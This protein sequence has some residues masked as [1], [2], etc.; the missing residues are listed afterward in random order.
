MSF[1]HAV[2]A[3]E[4]REREL[5]FAVA[6]SKLV[7][8][9]G[10]DAG[11]PTGFPGAPVLP[12][13]EPHYLG[14]LDGVHCF[15]YAVD[16]EPALPEGHAVSDLRSLWS[17]VSEQLWAVAGKAVQIVDW[18]RTHRFCGRCGTPTERVDADRSRRCPACS[19]SAY[20]RL[21]PAVICVVERGDELLLA[22]G[23]RFPAPFYSALAGFV[24]PGESLEGA[25]VREIR[26]EVGVEVEN[27]RYYGSQ[28]WP[29][30]HS[31]M[32]G[33]HATWKSGEIVIDP[34]EIAD[35]R[36]FPKDD[37]PLIPPPLSIARTLIDVAVARRG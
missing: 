4:R 7:T 11:G 36:F 12:A 32:I 30:P 9:T 10:G 5:W 20:P 14:G 1:D 27:V 3:P 28:P 35:A 19:L 6:G 34:S 22:H 26:E 29:F 18:D 37:L 31:L 33:F 8:V 25:V 15:A 23:T 17:T 21:A 2:R 24:E 16:A 13:T